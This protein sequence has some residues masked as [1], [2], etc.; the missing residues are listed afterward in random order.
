MPACGCV[1]VLVVHV[2]AGVGVGV[3]D[4]YMWVGVFH[5]EKVLTPLTAS[6]QPS[7]GTHSSLT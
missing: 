7:S 3:N 6:T 5:A 1:G 4:V 2:R